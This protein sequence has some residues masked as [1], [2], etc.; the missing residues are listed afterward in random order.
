S[1]V[2]S[3]FLLSVHYLRECFA[4]IHHLFPAMNSRVAV[5]GAGASGITAARQAVQYG[6]EPVIFEFSDA[7][8][9][10]WRYKP[11]ETDEPC[12]MKSTVIN[13][14][15]EMT[16]YS[17][18]P[19]PKEFAN[20]MHNTRMLEYLQLYAA[21]F[22]LMKYVRFGVK[23]T[24]IERSKTYDETGNWTVSYTD[25]QGETHREDFESVLLCNGHHTQPYW[26]QPWKGQEHFKGHII[27]SHSY[28]DHRGYED[29]VVVVVGIGNSGGDV[30]VELSRVAKEVYLVTRR[31]T[32]VFNRI[33]DYGVPLDISFNSR[34]KVM[35]RK[36]LPS[37]LSNWIMERKL[38]QRFDHAIYG[39][40]PQHRVFSAHPT[41][42]DEL[43]N[44]I[45]CGMITVEPNI[46]YFTEDGI[47]FE[48]GSHV[49]HVDEV[50]VST[51]YSF[52]F[53]LL[54]GGK[55]IPVVENQV[56]L[57]EFM[58]PPVLAPKNTLA[59][60]GLIQPLGSI[61]PLSEMQARVFFDAFTGRTKL[62][63]GER[64]KRSIEMK[65]REIEARYVKSRR[66][67]IQ[68][69]YLPYMDELAELIGAKPDIKKLFFSD[70][71]LATALLFGPNVPY[72][73][74]LSGP[75]PWPGARE[76]ILGVQERVVAA[77]CKHPLSSGWNILEV[78]MFLVV[79]VFIVL[80][81][82]CT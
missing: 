47:V 45:A 16:A 66:H 50:I 68:V 14:S 48:D 65:K 57:F 44:R 61:M 52:E 2:I 72:V 53:P 40:K 74:R 13:T 34:F 80:Y 6:V 69:D 24:N 25:K 19:P 35:L 36:A 18:F 23:V 12:V 63:S 64:M 30:A 26:P 59:I 8:G 46:A 60:I 67:T 58:Y 37:N 75:H 3:A 81:M 7:V 55:L 27:H 41:I 42:N 56:D 73:Y 79:L 51:G 70:P 28:K 20:F 33:F 62:P 5:V 78:I 21:H 77:T 39:L 22:D 49:D 10:L 4:Y 29:K 11:H 1:V 71:L 32:W 76:A 31:G 54:E 43:P 82:L 15:K 17:E 38:Q 9:G